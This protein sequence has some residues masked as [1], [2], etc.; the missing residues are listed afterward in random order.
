MVSF[1]VNSGTVFDEGW[2][3]MYEPTD[4]LLTTSEVASI[5]A[6]NARTV[7]G[8][9]RAG[10]IHPI[11]TPGGRLRFEASDIRRVIEA[12]A[13]RT[14]SAAGGQRNGRR[15]LALGLMR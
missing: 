14:G 8:W 11:R 3:A 15:C 4:Q 12:V 7:A 2:V 9:A 5:F 13:K 6:V 10:K 1:R